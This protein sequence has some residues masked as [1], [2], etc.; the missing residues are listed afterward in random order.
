MRYHLLPSIALLIVVSSLRGQEK[1]TEEIWESV[2][3][4]DR[5][6]RDQQIGYT[7]LSFETLTV[8]G[9]IIIRGTRQLRIN[10]KRDGQL[11]E[12]KGDTGTE[13]N[14]DGKVVGISMRQWLGKN[15]TLAMSGQPDKTGKFIE[16][17]VEG[18]S[19]DKPRKNAWD[20]RVIGLSGER[21]I[22]RDKK[23][24]P[25][26]SFSYRYYEP[27]LSI[28]VTIQIQVKDLKEVLLPR[29]GK[30]I[31]LCV[32]LLPQKILDVQLPPSMIWV[33]PKSYEQVLS[34]TDMFGL[35]LG[36][37]TFQRSSKALALG[38]LGDVPD[39]MKMQTLQVNPGVSDPHSLHG[40]VYEITVQGKDVDFA[41]LIK[42]D[43]RQTIKNKTEKSFELQVLARRSPLALE[44]VD[45]P[46][47]EFL[48]S[49]YYINSADEKV[50]KLAELAVGKLTDPWAKARAIERWVR[51]NMKSV[52]YTEAMA[53]SDHV[54]KT[55]SGD[56]SEFSML[57]AAMCK[58][59]RIPARTALG[60]VYVEGKAAHS[61]VFHMW[62]EVYIQGQWLGLDATRGQGYIGPGHIKITDHSWH[63]TE[64]FN[65]LLPVTGF[66]MAKPTIKV[67]SATTDKD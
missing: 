12:L 61:L 9:K 60:L 55:L 45:P 18:S 43:D 14:E 64:G 17:T 37:L 15:Q 36:M 38:P 22:L 32:E 34:Q 49:N 10:F 40:I 13:E 24:A 66:M 28:V 67:L 23:A 39:L 20:P 11:A 6:G 57:A 2:F 63:K 44:K 46:G 54:A 21:N 42:E 53:T 4:R 52:N 50:R 1:P 29:G 65:P 51:A 33:D 41:K 47:E 30:K 35:G 48:E 3:A 25:G 5:Q 19:D 8:N 31:L 27:T 26:D 58:A 7:R 59:Q 16:Y 62:T 56:C